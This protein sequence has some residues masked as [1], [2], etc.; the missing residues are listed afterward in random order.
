MVDPSEVWDLNLQFHKRAIAS[1]N[2][3][4]AQ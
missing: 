1:R 2:T 4:V 3:P